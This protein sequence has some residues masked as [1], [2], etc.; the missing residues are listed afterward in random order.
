MPNE[1]CSSKDKV[2]QLRTRIMPKEI[3]SSKDKVSQLRT[4]IMPKEICPT[5]GPKYQTSKEEPNIGKLE[6]QMP[7]EICPRMRVEL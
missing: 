1:I 2:S 3:C 6:F 5:N 4:L 7:K